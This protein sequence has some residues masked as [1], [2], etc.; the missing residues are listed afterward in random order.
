MMN[1]SDTTNFWDVL[2]TLALF[3]Y[4]LALLGGTVYIVQFWNWS[5][6]WFLMTMMFASVSIKTGSSKKKGDT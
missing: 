5:P 6:W 4:L 2:I 1:N 3:I